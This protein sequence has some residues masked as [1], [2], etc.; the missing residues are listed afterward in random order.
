MTESEPLFRFS[1]GVGLQTRAGQPAEGHEMKADQSGIQPGS[2]AC[3]GC[4]RR[5]SRWPPRGVWLPALTI[6]LLLF[7]GFS[8]A[9]ADSFRKEDVSDSP[10]IE[11]RSSVAVV[12]TTE[13]RFE[14]TAEGSS[15]SPR[16]ASSEVEKRDPCDLPPLRLEILDPA[17][18]RAVIREEGGPLRVVTPGSRV[19]GSTAVVRLVAA[20]KL[21]IERST[22]GGAAGRAVLLW[23]LLPDEPGASARVQCIE[24]EPE[25]RRRFIHP[26]DLEVGSAPAAAEQEGV[27]TLVRPP[28]GG[29]PRAD[30]GG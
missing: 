12:S 5:S 26:Q 27:R 11:D 15:P 16:E 28:E 6:L 9:F 19:A 4:P 24:P 23:I 1:R 8:S 10:R 30:G 18:Q 29:V 13:R 14:R 21:V 22:A 7:W 2:S 17:S 20:D 3:S 25:D